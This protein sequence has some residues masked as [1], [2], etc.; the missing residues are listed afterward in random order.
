VTRPVGRLGKQAAAKRLLLE[1]RSNHLAALMASPRH[2]TYCQFDRNHLGALTQVHARVQEQVNAIRTAETRRNLGWDAPAHE[3]DA[4]CS[5][6]LCLLVVA[7]HDKLDDKQLKAAARFYGNAAM[8]VLRDAVSKG[9]KDVETIRPTGS[10]D[11][12][13]LT[14]P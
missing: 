14:R 4:P 7:R 13:C 10:G 5:L 6:S 11:D 2:P 12:S 1:G 8:E 3:Y 9:Y